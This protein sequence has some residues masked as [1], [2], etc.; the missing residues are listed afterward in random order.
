MGREGRVRGVELTNNHVQHGNEASRGVK[1]FGSKRGAVVWTLVYV[2]IGCCI[3]IYLERMFPL[4]SK[5]AIPSPVLQAQEGGASPKRGSPEIQ[6]ARDV[7]DSS[8]QPR[9]V[10]PAD[11]D[12][13]CPRVRSFAGM[14]K[15]DESLRQ[16]VFEKVVLQPRSEILPH[17]NT[18]PH[19]RAGYTHLTHA[20]TEHT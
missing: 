2:M 10:P 15:K 17:V 6:G 19:L 1:N 16:N 13:K 11:A 9:L 3:G 5:D 8:T 18:H 4:S 14:A 12:A 20:R 7:A